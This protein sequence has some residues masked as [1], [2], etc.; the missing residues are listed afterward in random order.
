MKNWLIAVTDSAWDLVPGAEHIE[1]NDEMIDRLPADYDDFAAAETAMKEGVKLI[2]DIDGIYQNYYVDTPENRK[3]IM[4]YM[5]EHPKEVGRELI[6][7]KK[8]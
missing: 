2:S 3:I 8:E 4:E 1:R 6:G 5:R 7:R